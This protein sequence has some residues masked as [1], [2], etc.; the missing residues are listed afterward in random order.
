MTDKKLI[1]T[2]EEV[3]EE[4]HERFGTKM[5]KELYIGCCLCDVM[6]LIGFI[7][8]IIGMIERI[9]INKKNGL[10][11]KTK[12]DDRFRQVMWLKTSFER[13]LITLQKT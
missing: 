8:R 10:S 12:G 2:L 9:E 5:C 1:K 6:V 7:N 3:K 4:L 13:N 11:K